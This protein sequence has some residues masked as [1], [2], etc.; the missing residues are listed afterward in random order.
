[1]LRPKATLLA[2]VNHTCTPE[3]VWGAPAGVGLRRGYHEQKRC[4]VSP[5]HSP[6]PCATALLPSAV[7]RAV[8]PRSAVGA[9][10]LC[11]AGGIFGARVGARVGLGRLAN[12]GAYEGAFLHSHRFLHRRL[13]VDPRPIN[14][15][16]RYP[17]SLSAPACS[18]ND[19]AHLGGGRRRC[20]ARCEQLTWPWSDH[21]RHPT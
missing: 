17:H 18:G 13:L 7:P 8:T 20:P 14:P 10:H 1:M 6:P 21:V 9:P 11:G 19:G 5:T 2:S 12:R 4:L 16:C 15:S 3:I